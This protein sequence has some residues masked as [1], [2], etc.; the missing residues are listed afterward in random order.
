MGDGFLSPSGSSSGTAAA[1]AAYRWLDFALGTDIRDEQSQSRFES[2]LSRIE[3][4]FG[5]QRAVINF[6]DTWRETGTTTYL[7]PRSGVE[8]QLPAGI[9]ILSSTGTDVMLA[10]LVAEMMTTDKESS[11]S[12]VDDLRGDE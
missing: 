3:K 12:I 1:V 8:E 6:A 7:S 10:R 2:L 5:L 4:Y 9:S 11:L